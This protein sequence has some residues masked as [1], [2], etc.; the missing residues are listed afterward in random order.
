[1]KNLYTDN[2]KK[3]RNIDTRGTISEV[4][5]YM[6]SEKDVCRTTSEFIDDKHDAL[7][8]NL[9]L[10]GC[11]E[12]QRIATKD[13]KAEIMVN[14]DEGYTVNNVLAGSSHCDGSIYRNMDLWWKTDYRIADRNESK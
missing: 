4:D 3:M 7:G 1:M 6:K 13:H 10:T 11:K 2:S 9:S 12:G 14:D 8:Q 5:E